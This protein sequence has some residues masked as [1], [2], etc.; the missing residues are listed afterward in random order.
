MQPISTLLENRPSTVGANNFSVQPQC[1]LCL[2]GDIAAKDAHHGDTEN[3]EDA[4]RRRA[5]ARNG[6][7][8]GSRE[9]TQREGWFRYSVLIAIALLALAGLGCSRKPTGIAP[10]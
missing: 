10:S 1:S 8:A 2:C 4:Q 3:T 6:L 5:Q 9:T 7:A